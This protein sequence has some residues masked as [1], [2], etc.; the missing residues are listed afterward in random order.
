MSAVIQRDSRHPGLSAFAPAGEIV[1]AGFYSAPLSFVFPACLHARSTLSH[2]RAMDVRT[3][4]EAVRRLDRNRF[5]LT[6]DGLITHHSP[7]RL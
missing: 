6:L 7:R 2:C 4:L 3:D 1:L 5:K